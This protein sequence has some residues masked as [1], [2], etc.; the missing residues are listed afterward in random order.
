MPLVREFELIEERECA[1]TGKDQR[2]TFESFYG[3]SPSYYDEE[4][5][6]E[7][8]A[9]GCGAAQ[10]AAPARAD[11][12]R[13][14]ARAA[15]IAPQG[16]T[17]GRRPWAQLPA[18]RIQVW[19]FVLFRLE[20]AS[21]HHRRRADRSR[22]AR[23]QRITPPR[24]ALPES[25]RI[26]APR[27]LV[28]APGLSPRA[29]LR[30]TSSAALAA[31]SCDENDALMWHRALIVVVGAAAAFRAPARGLR[32]PRTRAFV[33]RDDD[34]RASDA[35]RV[36]V[37]CSVPV[38]WGTYAPAV[39]AVYALPAPPPGAVFSLF[40]YVVALGCL[41][42]LGRAAAAPGAAAPD[43]GAARAGLELGAYLYAGNLFQVVGLETVSAD[44]AAFLVQLTTVLVPV[45][46][47]AATGRAVARE[48]RLACAVAFAG[49][50]VLCAE[51]LAADAG[52]VSGD[53]CVVAAA[54]L[55][56]LHVVRLSALAGAGRERERPISAARRSFRRTR[57]R[58]IVSRN[59]L[60]ARALSPERA[61]AARSRRSGVEAPSSRAGARA[62]GVRARPRDGQGGLGGGVR[63]RRRRVPR[64]GDAL[65][66]GAALPR[67]VADARGGR[68]AR[69]GRA[70]V[71]RRD[72]R[73]GTR[74]IQRRVN[75][76]VPRARVPGKASTLR[77]RPER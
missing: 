14:D 17:Q 29:G 64:A 31:R 24:A 22:R 7:E 62:V 71:R 61:R 66:G 18:L 41:G 28:A 11:R 21:R 13:A 20:R 50:A 27:R 49:V 58:A 30:R 33:A 48:T 15:R 3:T 23:R 12:G 43:E 1:S 6:G 47:S 38:V 37:L 42:A 69:R 76:S 19:A 52:Q 68:R 9:C 39:K 74:V 55:Y 26:D 34:P 59:G 63:A 25:D 67:G 56:S 72:A 57:G 45:L 73:G 32:A 36:A 5:D 10:C 53:L 60:D 35:A 4:R 16:R 65:R 44:A 77:D 2:P 70:V 46:E 51:G 8:R 75:V 40:Y 54:V